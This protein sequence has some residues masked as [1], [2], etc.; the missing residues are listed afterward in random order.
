MYRKDVTAVGSTETTRSQLRSRGFP[1][2]RRR[3]LPNRHPA[4][5]CGH[6]RG[7]HPG[8]S[9]VPGRLSVHLR[10]RCFQAHHLFPPRPRPNPSDSGSGGWGVPHARGPSPHFRQVAGE[11]R[12]VKCT[13]WSPAGLAPGFCRVALLKSH[14]LETHD[15]HHATS[16]CETGVRRTSLRPQMCASHVPAG[17][18]ATLL[19]DFTPSPCRGGV[20]AHVPGR[21][22][23]PGSTLVPGG[24]LIRQ[25]RDSRIALMHRNAGKSVFTG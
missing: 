25:C 3:Y 5:R 6:G 20:R 4:P 1:S 22:S 8:L 17:R 19:P 12:T 21:G 9:T 10:R 18:E 15:N 14:R 23:L 24:A 2:H 13:S 16:I 11:T 7:S